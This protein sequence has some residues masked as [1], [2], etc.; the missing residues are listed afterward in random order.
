MLTSTLFGA[1][2]LPA[3]ASRRPRRVPC[4]KPWRVEFGPLYADSDFH[5]RPARILPE[6]RG[7]PT[8]GLSRTA[9]LR[10][11]A[12]RVDSGST[13]STA[14]L[15]RRPAYLGH[16]ELRAPIG[17]DSVAGFLRTQGSG[18]LSRGAVSAARFSWSTTARCSPAAPPI[19]ERKHSADPRKLRA[20]RQ[21]DGPPGRPWQHGRLRRHFGSDTTSTDPDSTAAGSQFGNLLISN[22]SAGGVTLANDVFAMGQLRTA[23]TLNTRTVFGSSYN[24]DVHGSALVAAPCARGA[25]S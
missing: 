2:K 12:C 24:L 23:D 6:H 18:H 8:A 22:A 15:Q 21:P 4:W 9:R 20:A 19:H 14:Y 16:G 25:P 13:Y 10:C 7:V 11:G 3:A 1:L 17:Q 5:R